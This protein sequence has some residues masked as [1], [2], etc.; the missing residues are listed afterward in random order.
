LIFGQRCTFVVL[1]EAIEFALRAAGWRSTI[2]RNTV[3]AQELNGLVVN[4]AAHRLIWMAAITREKGFLDA[5][6]AFEQLRTS[7]S[8]WAFD[9][10]G[11]GLPAES[12]PSARFHG[13]VQGAAKRAA[14]SPGGLMLLPS[15][16]ANETQPLC[17]LEAMF[18]GMPVIA[19]RVGG[20]P[21]IVGSGEDAAGRCLATTGVAELAEAISAVQLN[22]ARY[23]A[24]AAGRFAK[25]FSPEAFDR[26][27]RDIMGFQ[28]VSPLEQERRP[29]L[30]IK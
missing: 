25:F 3:T 28:S 15:R 9:V 11:A 7:D 5:Y 8:R 20:I 27:L 12:F 1:T 26:R 13:V 4:P 29:N 21:E 2:L 30:A 19:S 22:G 14:F 10:Y 17:L 18:V 23:G 16:Y 24:Q 6:A